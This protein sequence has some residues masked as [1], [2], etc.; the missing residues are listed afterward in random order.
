[1]A[2]LWA[3][4][5]LLCDSLS[6]PPDKQPLFYSSNSWNWYKSLGQQLH[7][8]YLEMDTYEQFLSWM[9]PK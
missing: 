3:A 6:F 7:I 2:L 4:A 5:I 1:M 9:L 8:V